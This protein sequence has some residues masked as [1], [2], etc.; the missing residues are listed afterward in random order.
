MRRFIGCAAAFALVALFLAAS[1]PVAVAQK[2]KDKDK[3]KDKDKEKAKTFGAIELQEGTDGKFR[4]YVRNAEG[5]LIASSPV[6]G[7][8]TEKDAKA[9]L[10]ELKGMLGKPKF[11]KTKKEK[12]EDKKDKDKKSDK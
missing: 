12:E 6:S 4:F 7:F 2:D 9:A 8:A 11:V 5:K 3:A 1:A 10:D